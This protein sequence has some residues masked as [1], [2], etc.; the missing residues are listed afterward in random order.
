[1][2]ELRSLYT[3]SELNAQIRL[4]L[5]KNFSDIWVAGEISNFHHHPSS[6]HHIER[7]IWCYAFF[8]QETWQW[9]CTF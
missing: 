2:P 7:L 5:E 6:C 8:E 1:M 4:L 9:P 3:V